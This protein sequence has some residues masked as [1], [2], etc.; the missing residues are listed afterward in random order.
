ML[1]TAARRDLPLPIECAK[2]TAR[3]DPMLKWCATRS[4]AI[5]G[6]MAKC[7]VIDAEKQRPR[8]AEED[9]EAE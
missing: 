6:Q 5:V 7:N 3:I 2:T 9:G 1:V 8:S 4:A